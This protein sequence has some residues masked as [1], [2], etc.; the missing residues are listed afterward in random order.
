MSG[1]CLAQLTRRRGADGRKEWGIII[2]QL[3]WRTQWIDGAG[4]AAWEDQRV[5]WWRDESGAGRFV[6]QAA[7]LREDVAVIIRP[8]DGGRRRGSRREGRCRRV[9]AHGTQFAIPITSRASGRSGRPRCGR[10]LRL[11]VL[12]HERLAHGSNDHL[13]GCC[14][15]SV[16]KD[17]RCPSETNKPPNPQWHNKQSHTTHPNFPPI[18]WKCD[19][20]T[21]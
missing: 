15:I 18:Q 1:M 10:R 9:L 17:C 12:H 14:K 8:I 3:I 5:V 4:R 11:L 20:F 2:I 16:Q 21:A 7:E 6:R 19:I 13:A